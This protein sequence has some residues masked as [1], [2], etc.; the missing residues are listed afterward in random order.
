VFV[1]QTGSQLGG[2]RFADDG[3]VEMEM[4]KWLRQQSKDFYAAGFD[5]LVN[6]WD[7]C[8]NV[9]GGLCQEMNV[10]FL[11]QISHVLCLISICDLPTDSPLHVRATLNECVLPIT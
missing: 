9:G 1:V 11:V 10:F 5:A 4:C 7:K 8:I 3:E 2:K 6:Q